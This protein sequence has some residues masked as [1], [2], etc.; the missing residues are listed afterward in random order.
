MAAAKNAG[1]REFVAD[2]GVLQGILGYDRRLRKGK[3]FARCGLVRFCVMAVDTDSKVF[4]VLAWN[5]MYTNPDGTFRP[6]C[7]YG[8][9]TVDESGKEL[10]FRTHTLPQIWN[11]KAMV[12]LRERMAS[13]KGVAGC[14]VCYKTEKVT[15]SSYRTW[16]NDYFLK[17]DAA[18]AGARD[19]VE[20]ATA[21]GQVVADLPTYFDIRLGNLCNLKCRS[22]DS[23]FS[24]SIEKDPV[25]SKY[26]SPLPVLQSRFTTEQPWFES[27]QLRDEL[28]EMSKNVVLVQLAGGEPTI[29]RIQMGW[30]QHLVDVG[31]SKDVAVTVWSNFTTLNARFYELM[32]KFKQFT[33]MMSID[34]H[35]QVLEYLRFPAKWE[36]IENNVRLLKEKVKQPMVT[37]FPVVQLCN[38]LNLPDL[39]EWAHG[40][41]LN[42]QL[43]RLHWPDQLHYN[44]LPPKAKAKAIAQLEA[45][46][47]RPGIAERQAFVG[48]VRALIAEFQQLPDPDPQAN[49]SRMQRFWQFTRDLDA[50]RG[51]TFEKAL[52]ELSEYLHE[53]YGSAVDPA[54]A[55]CAP[56]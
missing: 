44:L 56:V 54:L 36:Q 16:A 13:G 34:G 25:H 17:G 49:A 18:R 28:F 31:R 15:G 52:P 51:Q 42:V 8:E 29:N 4:C 20:R 27:D 7:V 46:L 50:S 1:I 43:N 40:H 24:S 9:K 41:G 30:L 3:D 35:S 45:Y 22:C 47:A 12:D 2:D 38:A 6:C 14:A 5:H 55:E 32:T 33:L 21:N 11:S 23:G 19:V 10:N 39:F 48:E 37:V 53:Y 26:M